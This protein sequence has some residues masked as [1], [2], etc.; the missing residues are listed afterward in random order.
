MTKNSQVA[1]GNVRANT[2]RHT[3]LKSRKPKSLRSFKN[4]VR[5]PVRKSEFSW[6]TQLHPEVLNRK[7]VQATKC[8]DEELKLAC[9][10]NTLHTITPRVLLRVVEH[11][12]ARMLM[13]SIHA[14]AKLFPTH[15]ED[16]G[17]HTYLLLA[18]TRVR[19]WVLEH[20]DVDRAR[21]NPW[22]AKALVEA[23]KLTQAAF[24]RTEQHPWIKCID[25]CPWIRREDWYSE[26]LELPTWK[27]P[28][29]RPR[30]FYDTPPPPLSELLKGHMRAPE[31]MMLPEYQPEL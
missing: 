17:H 11:V 18:T 4:G 3:Q 13:S 21:S 27:L 19:A 29:Q 31:L 30:E 25:S 22:H 24:C 26:C 8:Y 6:L 5:A 20:A 28:L 7:H 23:T 12:Q 14:Q 15:A 16:H 10:F 2:R 1:R 9:E